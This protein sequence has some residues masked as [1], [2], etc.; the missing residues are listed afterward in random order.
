LMVVVRSAMASSLMV[1]GCSLIVIQKGEDPTHWVHLRP[2]RPR[3]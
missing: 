1:A 3:V 2:G